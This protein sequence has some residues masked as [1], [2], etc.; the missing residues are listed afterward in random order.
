MVRLDVGAG[1]VHSRGEEN[2]VEELTEPFQPDSK[3][4][5]DVEGRH[6]QLVDT[7]EGSARVFDREL[8]EGTPKADVGEDVVK[9]QDEFVDVVRGISG[10]VNGGLDV[11]ALEG[12]EGKLV[13]SAMDSETPSELDSKLTVETWG[14]LDAMLAEEASKLV[15][16]QLVGNSVDS[17]KATVLEPELAVWVKRLDGQLVGADGDTSA[18]L[19]CVLEVEV[20]HVMDEELQVLVVVNS[21]IAG[22]PA[23]P[24]VLVSSTGTQNQL[25]IKVD[26]NLDREA[27][28]AAV[29]T[30]VGTKMDSLTS[31]EIV[32]DGV[33]ASYVEAL[34]RKS[35][36]ERRMRVT[37]RS[38][39]LARELKK[40]DE[41][42]AS[43][44]VES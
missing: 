1:D 27:S 13:G 43:Q 19:H 21:V 11:K 8:V 12:I 3:V 7:I 42:E 28:S 9:L 22:P 5:K 2:G 35:D 36:S 38:S 17:E 39:I 44:Q 40:I 33:A 10:A 15:E 26:S 24:D 25:V 29:W 23:G 31:F 34:P 16:G 20:P 37:R 18:V 4:G 30:T 6:D 41:D 32:L 14:M